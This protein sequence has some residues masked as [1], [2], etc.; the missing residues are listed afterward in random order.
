MGR[1]IEVRAQ[2][3]LGLQRIEFLP[4]SLSRDPSGDKRPEASRD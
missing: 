2:L 4:F 3:S 1:D